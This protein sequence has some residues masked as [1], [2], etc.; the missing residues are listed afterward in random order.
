MLCGNDLL[1]EVVGNVASRPRDP[2]EPRGQ[3]YVEMFHHSALPPLLLFPV[4][5]RVHSSNRAEGFYGTDFRY[6]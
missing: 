6:V 5:V 3:S 4:P 1:L 2:I